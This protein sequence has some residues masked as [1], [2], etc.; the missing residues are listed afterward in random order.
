MI[1]MAFDRDHPAHFEALYDAAVKWQ[2]LW[3]HYR[4]VFEGM[5]LNSVDAQQARKTQ[6]MMKELEEKR[7]PPVTPPPEE[8]VADL[9]DKFEAGE[10]RGGGGSKC[11]MG[12]SP[13]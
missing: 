10:W 6:R 2:P 1:E 4:G 12:P 7:P 3:N 13:T 5:P 9:L 11:E 8:R